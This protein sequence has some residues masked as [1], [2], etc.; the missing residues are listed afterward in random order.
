MIFSVSL[1][2]VGGHCLKG[3]FYKE[4]VINGFVNG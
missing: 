3:I 1:E 4:A 2:N